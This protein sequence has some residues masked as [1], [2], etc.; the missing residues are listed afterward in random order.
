ML[1]FDNVTVSYGDKPIIQNV[2]FA[3]SEHEKAVI[4]GKSGSGKSTILTT[5]IGAHIPAEGDVYFRGERL[6]RDNILNIR[7]SVAFIGQEPVLGAEKIRDALLLPFTYRMNRGKTPDESTIVT[8]LERLHLKP[9][10]LGREA[11]VV[12]GGEKQR[13]AIARGILHGKSVFLADEITSALDTESKSAV[14]EFFREEQCTLVS[15]SHDT[16]WFDICAKFIKVEDGKAVKISDSPEDTFTE[17]ERG[18]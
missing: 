15:V 17:P 8:T 12:S 3:V 14:L 7:R 4:Y 5:I 10:I 16:Q 11:S 18:A 13:V 9:E 2:S 1:K 6:S